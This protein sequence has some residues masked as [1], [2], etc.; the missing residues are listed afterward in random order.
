M[1]KHR[2]QWQLTGVQ[3]WKQSFEAAMGTDKV[4]AYLARASKHYSGIHC[5]LTIGD[6]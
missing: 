1:V 2:E 3:E 5:Y 6:F 4:A